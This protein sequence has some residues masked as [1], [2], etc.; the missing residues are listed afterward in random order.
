MLGSG[1]GN[2]GLGCGVLGSGW[3]NSG[4][5]CGSVGKWVAGSNRKWVVCTRKCQG[6]S[7]SG[8]VG[9]LGEREEVDIKSP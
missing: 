6:V 8:S 3:G 1:W 5:G 7:G 2:S 4:L 9:E